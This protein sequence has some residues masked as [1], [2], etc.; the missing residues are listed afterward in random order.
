MR[1]L[2]VVLAALAGA[3]AA[4]CAGALLAE[5]EAAG[6]GVALGAGEDGKTME[7]AA[8]TGWAP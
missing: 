8:N 5:F 6:E 7:V 2:S 3:G 1:S 4:G